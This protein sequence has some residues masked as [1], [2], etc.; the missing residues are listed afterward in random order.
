M[1]PVKLAS[2]VDRELRAVHGP[3]AK[4]CRTH[5]RG[6]ENH[7]GLGSFIVRLQKAQDNVGVTRAM[8]GGT[9]MTPLA[10]VS[11]GLAFFK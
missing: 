3:V 11:P 6:A 5:S 1:Q 2:K 9:A 8:G 7:T 4:R 10:T